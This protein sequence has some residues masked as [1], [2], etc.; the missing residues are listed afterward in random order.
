MDN[1]TSPR[2]VV[3]GGGA[4]GE[5]LLSGMFA[6]DPPPIT[7]DRVTVVEPAAERAEYLRTTLGVAVGELPAAASTADVVLIVVKP[8]ILAEVLPV[9]APGLR[10]GATV[11]SVV[12]GVP[13]A[14]VEAGLPA[15]TPV[16]R[17]Q[18]N[19]PVAV[20]AG[21]IAVEGGAHAGPADLD[22][23]RRL[24]E[25][26]GHVAVVPERLAD[27][28][29]A[30][31][32]SGPAYFFHFVE[33]LVDAAVLI[34]MPRPLAEETVTA[35]VAGSVELLKA[36]GPEFTRL[37]AEVTSPGGVT[38]VGLRELELGAL[39][40]VIQRAVQEGHRRAQELGR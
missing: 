32:A 30:L 21:M 4:M 26:A 35:T 11:I 25:V 27:T 37:K 31:S 33:A 10:P 15:G 2:V 5:A 16:V 38:A 12:G 13:T 6:A 18:P 28:F 39:R 22:L 9:L 23:A 20:G 17:C 3:V 29:T 8:H 34:G 19:T 7:P 1:L 24:L 40:G 36:R 14:T